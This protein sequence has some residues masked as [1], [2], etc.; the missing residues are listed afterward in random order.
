MGVRE[1][2]RLPGGGSR[3]VLVSGARV[4]KAA[5]EL[6]DCE[7]GCADVRRTALRALAA[8]A[9]APGVEP[10]E[11]TVGA[12]IPVFTRSGDGSTRRLGVQRVLVVAL[13]DTLVVAAILDDE[14]GGETLY[15][16]LDGESGTVR[17]RTV[18]SLL[19]GDMKQSLASASSGREL[20]A[21]TARFLAESG[22][23]SVLEA[24]LYD[25]LPTIERYVATVAGERPQRAAGNRTPALETA[26]ERVSKVPTEVQ[27]CRAGLG[28]A[29]RPLESSARERVGAW[30]FGFPWDAADPAAKPAQ[31]GVTKNLIRAVSH[32]GAAAGLARRTREEALGVLATADAVTATLT[33][34]LP[35]RHAQSFGR[36]RHGAVGAHRGAG[37]PGPALRALGARRVLDAALDDRRGGR[38]GG[39]GARAR[40]VGPARGGTRRCEPFAAGHGDRRRSCRRHRGL[41]PAVAHDRRPARRRRHARRHRADTHD[42]RRRA[43]A[44]PGPDPPSRRPDRGDSGAPR[45]TGGAVVTTGRPASS[46]QV[47]EDHG[48]SAPWRSKW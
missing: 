18:R 24:V 36:V 6:A 30:R 11:E 17:R 19:K 16:V 21:L 10:P 20:A 33:A 45:G 9:G 48:T 40:L 22:T 23:R 29:L 38:G 35:R 4:P 14:Q 26:I 39:G 25:D 3:L 42:R 27:R 8:A 46:G 12:V 32:V 31:E 28:A 5:R 43:R 44:A 13:D 41:G 7:H 34:D 2:M 15:D 37:R 1:L 47:P